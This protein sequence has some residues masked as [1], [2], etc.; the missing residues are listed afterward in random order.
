[1]Q[2][3]GSEVAKESGPKD[4]EE[5]KGTIPKG[6]RLVPKDVKENVEPAPTK[7]VKRK[8]RQQSAG[9]AEGKSERP[10]SRAEKKSKKD[11]AE[12]KRAASCKEAAK[13]KGE[14]KDSKTEEE[15]EQKEEVE[16]DEATDEFLS[17][18]KRDK[19]TSKEVKKQP[20]AKKFVKKPRTQKEE[21][22]PESPKGNVVHQEKEPMVSRGLQGAMF[23]FLKI[24]KES[25]AKEYPD[26]TKSELRKMAL[27]QLETQSVGIFF[28]MRDS[29]KLVLQ[30][31]QF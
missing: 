16:R 20:I 4:S 14:T 8:R 6:E 24:A 21:N 13:R 12:D 19:D 9:A 2:G 28:A 31:I 23:D 30:H 22:E 26:K 25:L 5:Q 10:A 1:M 7:E 3:Q 18:E 29:L 11:P 17:G 27:E 15:E